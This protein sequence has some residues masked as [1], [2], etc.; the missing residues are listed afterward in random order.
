MIIRKGN[1]SNV[2]KNFTEAEYFAA[3]FGTS[4]INEFDYSDKVIEAAQVI[5]DFFGV[6]MR[7][8][9]TYRTVEH[10]KK[11][12]R[13]GNSQHTKKIAGDFAFSDDGNTLLKYHQEILNKGELYKQLR[14][15]G[16]NAF[17]LYDNFLHID[18]RSGGNQP[19]ATYGS[20]AFW[21][22]RITTKKKM[23]SITQIVNAWNDE[24]DGSEDFKK[25]KIGTVAII[26]AILLFIGIL[27]Y[28]RF[29]KN[30]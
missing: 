19:D 20:Y 17:G 1:K 21:D 10:E 27:I 15:A 22:N 6:P 12:G 16:I 24:E 30:K 18:A 4:S 28:Y 26:V 3:S 29:K 8:N 23:P 25:F 2:S 14:A 5:R 9:A 11:Q 13:S 7:V